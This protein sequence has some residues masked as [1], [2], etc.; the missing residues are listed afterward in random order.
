[1]KYFS[2][3]LASAATADH[4][5]TFDVENLH[6]RTYAAQALN[7]FLDYSLNFNL[8]G[9]E[10]HGCY[11]SQLKNNNWETNRYLGGPR[12]ID[13]LDEICKRWVM[14]RNCNDRYKNGSCFVEKPANSTEGS[15][16]DY[17]DFSEFSDFDS[18][19]HQLTSS[20]YLAESD[21]FGNSTCSN[22]NNF[23]AEETCLI[24]M[25]FMNE[26]KNY[27]T[28]EVFFTT[29]PFVVDSF[30][31]CKDEIGPSGPLHCKECSGEVPDSMKTQ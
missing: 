23:C 9:I 16:F 1:M 26:I 20:Y 25:Y 3:F 4:L 5:F 2:L 19:D 8:I 18:T 29:F 22:F 13:E 30:G 12:G 11:C 17:S 14:S 27:L 15:G 7:A 24:D 6:L 31:V 21:E 10:D 28:G